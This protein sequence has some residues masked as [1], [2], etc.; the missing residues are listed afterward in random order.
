MR[1]ICDDIRNTFDTLPRQGSVHLLLL[2][3]DPTP[4]AVS[5][6]SLLLFNSRQRRRSTATVDR[7]ERPSQEQYD[8]KGQRAFSKQMTAATS[9][10]QQQDS[11]LVLVKIAETKHFLFFIWPHTQCSRRVSDDGLF[12]DDETQAANSTSSAGPYLFDW[13]LVL[14]LCNT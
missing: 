4:K 14:R 8:R 1:I 11:A 2:N 5:T 10:Q 7:C 3:H 12:F 13:L 9:E 6:A